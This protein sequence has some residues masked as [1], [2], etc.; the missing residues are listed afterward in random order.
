MYCWP[1]YT[2]FSSSSRCR[3][4]CDEWVSSGVSTRYTFISL[5]SNQIHAATLSMV[6]FAFYF[7]A[8]QLLPST[9]TPHFFYSLPLF[10]FILINTK[11][12]PRHFFSQLATLF[13]KKRKENIQSRLPQNPHSHCYPNPPIHLSALCFHRNSSLKPPYSSILILWWNWPKV[14][15]GSLTRFPTE[16]V[17]GKST[18]VKR[19]HSTEMTGNWNGYNN[20]GSNS[21][22]QTHW[23]G[24]PTTNPTPAMHGGGQDKKG[25]LSR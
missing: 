8:H 14:V 11:R 18:I 15:I 21:D 7:Y 4:L 16:N 2:M 3:L 13:G 5:W 17:Y 24:L 20:F 6:A 1:S 23:R 25:R 12:N 9:F 10:S 22:Q 19:F